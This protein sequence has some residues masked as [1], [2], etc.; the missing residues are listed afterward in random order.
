MV[1]FFVIITVEI[2]NIKLRISR[3]LTDA[4]L[5]KYVIHI[6]SCFNH[7]YLK[8]TNNYSLFV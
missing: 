3:G 2:E 8:N 6:Y 5:V 1:S 4:H 7:M